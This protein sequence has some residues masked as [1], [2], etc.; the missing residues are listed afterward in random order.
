MP[1]VSQF[2]KWYMVKSSPEGKWTILPGWMNSQ[3][4]HLPHQK[5]PWG[6]EPQGSLFSWGE[7][8]LDIKMSRKDWLRLNIRCGSGSMNSFND[9]SS[10][11]RCQLVFKMCFKA[12]CWLL[13][14]VMRRRLCE[15]EDAGVSPWISSKSRNGNPLHFWRLFWETFYYSYNLKIVHVAERLVFGNPLHCCNCVLLAGNAPWG[16]ICLNERGG[17]FENATG[18]YPLC[19][20]GRDWWLFLFLHSYV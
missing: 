17:H 7:K 5:V 20:C 18:S 13:Y 3:K 16:W 9:G 14:F 19:P 12:Q 8:L 6:K 4:S 15:P 10:R 11:S 2:T 1:I